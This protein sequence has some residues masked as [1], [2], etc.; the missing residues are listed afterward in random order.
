MTWLDP[1]DAPH[2]CISPG[3]DRFGGFGRKRKGGD[4]IMRLRLVLP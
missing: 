2:G 4:G 3:C 1:H